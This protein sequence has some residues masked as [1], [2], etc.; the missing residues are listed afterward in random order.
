MTRTPDIP[1][2]IENHVGESTD[3]GIPSTVE[4]LKHPLHPLIVTFPI[5]FLVGALGTDIGYWVTQDAFWARASVWLLG[6]GFVSGLVAALT[7]MLDFLRI[8]RVRKR[9]S[10]W[11]HM[12]GNIVALT[13]TLVNW[14]LRL[15]R[16]ADSVSL[17]GLVL[18]LLVA[19]LLG[20]TGWHGAE[21]IYRH[22]I[23]VIGHN[24]R[25]EP[26]L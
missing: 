18:S 4:I 26:E 6:A 23:A 17:I 7:G 8:D 22:K 16:P 14:L 2:L 5:A 10:G 9:Q 20:F 19:S 15:G 3:S 25:Q 21:L 11:I 13:L 1:L 12:I 24:S